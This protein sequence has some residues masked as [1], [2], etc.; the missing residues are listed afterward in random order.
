MG[1]SEKLLKKSGV[2]VRWKEK[3]NGEIN[4]G[5]MWSGVVERI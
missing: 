2:Y 4:V 1:H 3:K 5:S